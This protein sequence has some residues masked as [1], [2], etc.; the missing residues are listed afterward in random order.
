MEVGDL[1]TEERF[2]QDQEQGL[3]DTERT[4]ELIREVGDNLVPGLKL[5]KDLP[6]YHEN[7]KCPVLDIQV[8]LE[9][10]EGF[11]KIRHSFFQ[12]P[13]TS[14]LVFHSGGAHS[15]RSKLITLAEELRR[16]LLNMETF[17]TW[18]EQR[19]VIKDF[20]QKMCDS[21]YGE[22]TRLEVIKS[23]ITKYYR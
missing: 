4:L 18:D 22:S 16:R 6:E 12:K 1:W 11:M 5:T 15:W 21:G 3:S 19:H 9:E 8:W 13:T 14:P 20:L 10:K 2:N 17:H 7:G 23:A